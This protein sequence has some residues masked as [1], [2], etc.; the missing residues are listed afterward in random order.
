[1]EEGS[2]S[3]KVTIT[4]AGGSV[5]TAGETVV[6]TDSYLQVADIPVGT[7]MEGTSF[8]AVVAHLTDGDPNGVASDYSAT[9]YWGDGTNSV[10][11]IAGSSGGGFDVVGTAP[12][13]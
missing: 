12:R 9:I 10:G 13:A 4:D 3:L 5:A 1:L 2:Y 7:Q 8:T 6:V 11:S